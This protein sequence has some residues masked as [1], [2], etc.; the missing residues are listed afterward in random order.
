MAKKPG[1]K[2]GRKTQTY[3]KPAPPIQ[4]LPPA[5]TYLKEHGKAYWERIGP[6][7]IDAGILTAGHLESFGLLCESW[8]EY[9]RLADWL[10][11][12]PSRAVITY[13]SGAQSPAP[14]VQMRD[15]ASKMMYNLWSKFG[16]TPHALAGL[17]RHGGAAAGKSLPAIAEFA[18]GK[19]ADEEDVG[20]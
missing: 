1:T 12:D 15:H 8:D 5:P 11:E 10:A 18:K 19:Y 2:R 6:L 7:L 13:Q 4:D 16:L 3:G 17:G 9:R 14:Q 20:G